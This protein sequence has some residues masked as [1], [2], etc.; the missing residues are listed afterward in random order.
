[1]FQKPTRVQKMLRVAVRSQSRPSGRSCCFADID[2]YLSTIG[3]VSDL[4]NRERGA[5]ALRQCTESADFYKEPACTTCQDSMLKGAVPWFATVNV[6][7]YPPVPEHLPRL[8]VVEERLVAPRLPFKRLRRLTWYNK[9]NRGQYG[10][11][12]TNYPITP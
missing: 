2:A 5:C 3:G 1:M 10:S 9:D 4:K 11:H 6:Y 12:I 7:K 8:N